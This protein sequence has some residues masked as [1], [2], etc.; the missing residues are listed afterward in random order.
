MQ[1]KSIVVWSEGGER[2][3]DGMEDG[4]RG[5]VLIVAVPVML[6]LRSQ[7]S[8]RWPHV[9]VGTCTVRPGR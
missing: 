6:S 2:F 7:N 4:G 9:S 3:G 8:V 1:S 5:D